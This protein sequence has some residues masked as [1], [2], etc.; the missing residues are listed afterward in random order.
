MFLHNMQDWVLE[1][2][3][4]GVGAGGILNLGIKINF[5]FFKSFCMTSGYITVYKYFSMLR[6]GPVLTNVHY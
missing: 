3:E 6:S 4:G 5:F 1:G 2:R